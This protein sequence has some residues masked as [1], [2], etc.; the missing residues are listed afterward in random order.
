VDSFPAPGGIWDHGTLWSRNG[1]P[2]VL[3]GHPYPC[4]VSDEDRR[5]LAELGRFGT[6]KVALDDRPSFYG[7]GTHH[8]RVELVEPRGPFARPPATRKTRAALRAARKA[9]APE[10]LVPR[11][12]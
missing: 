7:F 4:A 6:L 3:V 2:A 8:I 12:N 9:F 1:E 5:L 10:G 11:C